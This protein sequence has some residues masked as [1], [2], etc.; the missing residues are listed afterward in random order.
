MVETFKT[1]ERS[2]PTAIIDAD[3]TAMYEQEWEAFV[4]APP[5]RPHSFSLYMGT[6]LIRNR[7]NLA[8]YSRF[9]SR[10]MWWS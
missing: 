8:H 6:S 2:A 7:P 5:K 10:A 3:P 4:A 1:P 9:M